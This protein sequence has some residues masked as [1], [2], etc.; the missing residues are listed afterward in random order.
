MYMHNFLSAPDAI[1]A[2]QPGKKYQIRGYH[3]PDFVG[4]CIEVSESSATFEVCERGRLRLG[5]EI[6]VQLAS[7][8]RAGVRIQAV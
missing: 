8:R 2:L 3:T 7:A 5:E 6:G 4:A 1:T